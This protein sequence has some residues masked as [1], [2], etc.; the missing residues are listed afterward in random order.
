MKNNKRL[1]GKPRAMN[2]SFTEHR[3]ELKWSEMNRQQR[4]AHMKNTKNNAK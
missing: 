1:M 4:R 3:A 2:S